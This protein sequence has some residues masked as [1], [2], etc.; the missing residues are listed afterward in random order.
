MNQNELFHYGVKRRSGRYPWGSGERP[1]QRTNVKGVYA[2]TSKKTPTKE[3]AKAITKSILI[4]HIFNAVDKKSG[5]IFLYDIL[6][7]LEEYQKAKK[8]KREN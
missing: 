1:Y 4:G 2:L 8:N 5:R 7:N 6:S 3:K